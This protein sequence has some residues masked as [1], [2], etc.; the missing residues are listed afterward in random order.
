MKTRNLMTLVVASLLCLAIAGTAG[1]V[2]ITLQEAFLGTRGDGTYFSLAET[3]VAQNIYGTGN[4]A[5]FNFD[6]TGSGGSAQLL[7]GNTPIGGPLMPSTDE[8]AYDLALYDTPYLAYVDFFISDWLF[9]IAGDVA[10]ERV[11]IDIE[12]G[13]LVQTNTFALEN[14]ADGSRRVRVDLAAAGV[15]DLL[16]DGQLMAMAIAPAF[17]DVYNTFT[18]DRVVLHAEANTAPVPE[19]TTMLLLGTG[20]AGLAAFR[21][22]RV[23]T[24]KA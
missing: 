17:A 15:L 20:L 7:L 6:L 12:T 1:A 3:T 22:G 14:D 4:R 9:E 10:Q 11:R 2:P 5:T 24:K 23:H 21:R 13:A 16:F 18:I 19:P 8:S